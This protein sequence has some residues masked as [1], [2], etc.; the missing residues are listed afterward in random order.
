[1]WWGNYNNLGGSAI[2]GHSVTSG[3]ATDVVEICSISVTMGDFG[4]CDE[5]RLESTKH[6]LRFDGTVL[7]GAPQVI[8]TL[9]GD[10]H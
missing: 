8:R 7:L 5:I 3:D 6:R 1:M 4:L 9:K 10:C 2:L